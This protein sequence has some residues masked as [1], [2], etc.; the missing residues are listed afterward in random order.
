MVLR[1][2][3]QEAERPTMTKLDDVLQH[4]GAEPAPPALALLD[5]AVI[6]GLGQRREARTARRTLVLAGCVSVL[7]GLG[8]TLVPTS[9]ASAEQLLGVP[10]AAPSHLLAD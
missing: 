2:H 6:A 5:G 9:S 1:M 7:V 3:G 8:E 10:D 4:M